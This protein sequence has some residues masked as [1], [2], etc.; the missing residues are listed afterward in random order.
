VTRS[1]DLTVHLYAAILAQACNF[2]VGTMASIAELS[3]QKL[4]W[5]TEWHLREETLTAA[6]AAIVNFHHGLPLSK[7]WGDGTFSS[8]DG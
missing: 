6:M 8:S 2:G 7:A 5:A 4:A 3:Y 1:K